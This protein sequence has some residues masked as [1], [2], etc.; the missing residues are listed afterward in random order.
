MADCSHAT[1]LDVDDCRYEHPAVTTAAEALAA[2]CP[3]PSQCVDAR[4]YRECRHGVHWLA[5]GPGGIGEQHITEV[6]GHPAAIAAAIAPAVLRWA[7]E[8]LH[9]T[10]EAEQD[11]GVA[12]G[13]LRAAAGL[14]EM[15]DE[16]EA[17]ASVDPRAAQDSPVPPVPDAVGAF[18]GPTGT[19]T[20]PRAES[21]GCGASCA[22]CPCD[23]CGDCGHP[24]D[25]HEGDGGRCDCGCPGFRTEPATP[26]RYCTA[27]RPGPVG[28]ECRF[29]GSRGSAE[30]PESVHGPSHYPQAK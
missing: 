6:E 24:R 7:A 21:D 13:Y 18:S 9:A 16:I 19:P 1:C 25:W 4:I 5:V 8:H 15:A 22:P 26:C 3:T 30:R 14:D 23:E 11:A 27:P 29:P 17:A 10:G 20:H 12:V 28:C 2:A